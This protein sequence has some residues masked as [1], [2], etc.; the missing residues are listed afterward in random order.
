MIGK[1]DKLQN[2]ATVV[3][4][5]ETPR[6]KKVVLSKQEYGDEVEYATWCVDNGGT[7]Y[8]GHYFGS[9]VD[10]AED[11]FVRRCECEPK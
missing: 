8:W 1:G 9:R 2:G 6:G 5:R 11:D 10:R 3:N 4:Y 7:P